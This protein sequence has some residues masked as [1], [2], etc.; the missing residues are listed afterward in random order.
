MYLQVMQVFRGFDAVQCLATT[1][2]YRRF[3]CS[4]LKWNRNP[5]DENVVEEG[6]VT[7]MR[8]SCWPE[9]CSCS[10]VHVAHP[11]VRSQQLLADDEVG[12]NTSTKGWQ[13]SD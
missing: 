2:Q 4:G 11:P 9:S 13:Q 12:G 7:K 1:Q 5:T 3:S 6:F 10:A 8:M